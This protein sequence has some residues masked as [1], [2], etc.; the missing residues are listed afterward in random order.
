MSSPLFLCDLHALVKTL[1]IMSCKEYAQVVNNQALQ[2]VNLK[3]S[4]ISD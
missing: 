4:T 1:H 2:Q 3:N